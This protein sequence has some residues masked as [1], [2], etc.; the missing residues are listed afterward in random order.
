M[1]KWLPAAC[2]L[3]L[4]LL[5]HHTTR[6]QCPY[7]I[8][9]G[10]NFYDTV[11]ATP[12]GINTMLIKFPKARPV[13][14]MLTCM[15]LC[16]S[17]TGV[18][19]SVSVENNS[20]SPQVANVYYIRTDQVTGPGLSGALS[21]SVNHLYG[22]YNLGA[23]NGILG[24]G[25]D[26][27]A[28][29]HDTVMNA[30]QVCQTVTN[31]DSLYQFYGQDSLTYQYTITAFTNVTCTGGN[32]NS[33]VATSALVRFR[34]TYCTCPGLYLGI[35]NSGFEAIRTGA[36][37]ARL[38]W[39]VEEKDPATCYYVPELSRNGRDFT[40]LGR[41]TAGGAR[42]GD[43]LGMDYEGD[44][45]GGACYFRLRQVYQN[46]QTLYSQVRLLRFDRNEP[47]FFLYPNPSSGPIGIKFAY[48]MNGRCTVEVLGSAGQ[49]LRKLEIPAF[50]HEFPT[51]INLP[52]G[53]YWIKVTDHRNERTEIREL[54]IQ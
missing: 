2:W 32:Y 12:A 18:V 8:T 41:V 35:Q 26:F 37:K 15:R 11:I 9:P 42:P 43:R 52:K 16:I 24:S 7:G 50:G 51:M 30:V 4:A 33:T 45:S 21:S 13:N 22:P 28:I 48:P 36:Q 6:A 17:I 46:G 23:T 47:L 53:N 49:Q 44:K 5:S 31:P 3:S 27:T 1:K 54:I 10:S 29:S 39:T 34:M 40:A 20:A 19:D 14:G 25:P 38:N